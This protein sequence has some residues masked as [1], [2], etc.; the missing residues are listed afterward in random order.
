MSDNLSLEALKSKFENNSKVKIGTYVLGGLVV[1]ILLYF[2]YR[3]FIVKPSNEKSNDGW[4]VAMNY[5]TK[6]STDQAI[7]L[8]VP[9]VKKYDGN[10]GGEIGQY[11]LGTQYM[12]KGEFRKALDN[13]EGVSVNDSYL[14]IFCIGLQGDCLSEMKKY[15]DAIGMG[16]IKRSPWQSSFIDICG[17]SDR[18]FAFVLVADWYIASARAIVAIFNHF[19]SLFRRHLGSN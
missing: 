19:P 18:N 2:S 10:S 5:I 9:F 16:N 11:L 4:W 7:K 12:K 14:S 8:L 13:F 3:Q 17:Y 6:D 1:L 15:A